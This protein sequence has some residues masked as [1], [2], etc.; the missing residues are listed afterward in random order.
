[1]AAVVE[2]VIQEPPRLAVPVH[3]GAAYTISREE[4]AVFAHRQRRLAVIVPEGDGV[5]GEVLE[6]F[7]LNCIP[8][9]VEVILK[10]VGE[11][12]AIWSTL[13]RDHFQARF[14]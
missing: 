2:E 1:M 10:E 12:I 5:A 11:G 3:H 14:V 7:T 6:Q 4:R 9:F 8:P 13:E